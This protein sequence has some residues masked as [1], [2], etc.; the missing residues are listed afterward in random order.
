MYFVKV[1]KEKYLKAISKISKSLCIAGS[2]IRKSIKLSEK[3][4]GLGLEGHTRCP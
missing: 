3:V 1:Q 2:R 4:L